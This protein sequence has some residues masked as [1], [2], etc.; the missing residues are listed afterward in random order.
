M[1]ILKTHCE[2][3]YTVVVWKTPI[4]GGLQANT[5][6]ES[7]VGNLKYLQKFLRQRYAFNMIPRYSVFEF[8][9]VDLPPAIF[10]YENK[11]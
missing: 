5:E 11:L 2:N 4:K 3:F 8:L 6:Q 9:I 7:N 10:S 1:G